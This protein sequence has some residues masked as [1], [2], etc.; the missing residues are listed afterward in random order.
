MYLNR[1]GTEFSGSQ[2]NQTVGS[3]SPKFK[4]S[5]IKPKDQKAPVTRK[6]KSAF[7][8]KVLHNEYGELK[9]FKMEAIRADIKKNVI[10]IN[11]PVNH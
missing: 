10:N 1:T 7:G 5:A 8:K 4:K 11:L 9:K 2:G 3:L 6:E